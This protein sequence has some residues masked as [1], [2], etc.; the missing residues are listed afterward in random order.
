M[1]SDGLKVFAASILPAGLAGALFLASWKIPEKR[2]LFFSL[3][4]AV[5]VVTSIA[6]TASSIQKASDADKKELKYK[7]DV[8][9]VSVSSIVLV[10]LLG[11]IGKSVS[12]R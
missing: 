11:F 10:L 2:S 9:S 12:G 7:Y 1:S 3:A 8:A 4:F 6:Q 5:Y